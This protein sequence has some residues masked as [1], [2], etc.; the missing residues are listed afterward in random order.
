M[1]KVVLAEERNKGLFSAPQKTYTKRRAE[2]SSG[3][4][5]ENQGCAPWQ[6]QVLSMDLSL[7]EGRKHPG[8]PSGR[9]EAFPEHDGH[10]PCQNCSTYALQYLCTHCKRIPSVQQGSS[11]L[12]SQFGE[13]KYEQLFQASLHHTERMWPWTLQQALEQCTQALG[14]VCVCVF[15]FVVL[16]LYSPRS[17]LWVSDSA[18]KS[19]VTTCC[20][21]CLNPA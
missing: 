1:E 12:L 5:D 2:H 14:W 21:R 13:R 6:D 3:T 17:F 20:N 15:V 9:K 10:N 8:F 18:T 19:L 7:Q 11:Q 16:C 4:Q